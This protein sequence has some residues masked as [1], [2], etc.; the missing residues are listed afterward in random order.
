MAVS[1]NSAGDVV[2]YRTKWLQ[3]RRYSFC[4]VG[5]RFFSARSRAILS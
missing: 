5:A 3:Q 4:G 1:P 2:W